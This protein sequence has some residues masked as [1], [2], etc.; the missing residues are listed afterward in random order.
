MTLSPRM[1]SL[2]GVLLAV[3]IAVALYASTVLIW[4]LLTERADATCAAL[5]GEDGTYTVTSIWRGGL[6]WECEYA[7]DWNPRGTIVLTPDD[8]MRS[9]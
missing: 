1:N 3:G 5:V 8:L 2:I 4:N 9:G 6:A 7:T